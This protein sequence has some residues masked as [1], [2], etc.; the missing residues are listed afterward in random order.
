MRKLHIILSLAPN[1]SVAQE[2][3]SS[4]LLP[5]PRVGDIKSANGTVLKGTYFFPTSRGPA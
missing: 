3:A 2:A 5:A 1:A 4:Q